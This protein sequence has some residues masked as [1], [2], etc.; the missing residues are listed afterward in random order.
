MFYYF[1][2]LIL[3]LSPFLLSL[4]L[5]CLRS[6]AHTCRLG[7]FKLRS[8]PLAILCL[9][10][11]ALSFGPVVQ[12]YSAQVSLQWDANTDP[13]VAG[14]KVYYGTTSHN[15]SSHIDVG[16]TTTYTVSN[17]PD[18]VTHY[19]A[20]TD[21]SNSGMESG[22]SN[23]VVLNAAPNCTYSLSPA[24]Q[25]FGA[26][27]AS[28]SVNVNAGVGCPWI[29][30]SNATWIT[31]TS[32]SSVTGGGT[33]NYSVASN[34]SSASRSGTMTIAQQTFTVTQSGAPQ[35]TLS[36]A[37]SG[38]GTG[39]VT[40]NPVG[41]T[42]NAGTA[43]TLTATPDASSTFAGWSGACTG[44]SP[45]CSVTMDGNTEVTATFNL[46]TFTINASAGTNGSISPQGTAMVNYGASQNF[47]ITPATGYGVSDIQVDG[48]SV[49]TVNSYL[50]GN[51]MT[52]HTISA[53]FNALP[54][55]SDSPKRHNRYK[56]YFPTYRRTY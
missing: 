9:L 56:K 1:S 26:S 44:T 37:K 31:I 10:P 8:S 42:F 55:P 33:I 28:G 4:L 27:P 16:K 53:S 52:N 12:V 43:V 40:N 24:A 6:L 46:K 7:A 41:T 13:I 14:Y 51:V 11:L 29:A 17:L 49:G 54:P 5:S 19:F 35:Y 45:A 3:G 34:S 30:V 36:T 32:N 22:F 38:T 2:S 21:Y 20:T 18:G 25:S 50:F 47:T 15:Y 39:T 23:E 48:V